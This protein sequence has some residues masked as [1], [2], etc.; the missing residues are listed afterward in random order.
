MSKITHSRSR[1][2][3]TAES[4][5]PRVAMTNTSLLVGF[6]FGCCLLFM[7][8]LTGQRPWQIGPWARVS[9]QPVIAPDPATSFTD[10]VSGLPVHWEALHT[11]N[12]AAIVRKGS[13]VVLYRAE[14]DSGEMSIGGH[15]S[16]LGMAVSRDG[17]HFDRLPAPVFYPNKDSEQERESPGGVEDPRLVQAPDGTFVLTYT[18]W[19]RRDRMFRI[20]IAR[21]PDLQHWTKYG[22]AFGTTGK[23][24]N[25]H[26][27]SAG[28]VTEQRGSELV[29]ARIHGRFWMY[30]GEGE[31]HIA[32]SMDL[33]HWMPLE[34]ASGSP[35]VLLQRR[36]GR[37]D[38]NFPETG[39]PAVLT[40][41][42]IV[43]LYNA[44]NAAGRDGDPAV[45]AGAYTVQEALFAADAPERLLDRTT[46]PVLQPALPWERS[47]QYVA[48]T[49]FAEGL[50]LFHKHWLL[51]Y[52]SAD[53]FVGVANAGTRPMA[54]T[55]ACVESDGNH[56]A[57]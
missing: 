57:Q 17:V 38:S 10:P 35:M 44:K 16:R 23:Y 50:I 14:D 46:C 54:A 21:S 24:A 25:M 45:G 51:Y 55:T 20:G 22:P 52:G 8:S 40:P 30:W 27:K 32:S 36:P 26:Y 31:I 4:R 18:Q 42:G 12:P 37:S 13:V 2:W 1:A 19:S 9:Q 6:L 34:D 3:R 28:I 43:L 5:L 33:V 11:F 41:R 39:P 48:G 47:G 49:T 56:V 15:T 53:S 29:A 7:P